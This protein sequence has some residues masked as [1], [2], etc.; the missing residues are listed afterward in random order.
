[1]GQRFTA[2]EARQR[3]TPPVFQVGEGLGTSHHLLV[4]GAAQ[5]DTPQPMASRAPTRSTMPNFFGLV[6]G[7]GAQQE[8]E[9]GHMGEYFAKYQAYGQE[10]RDALSFQDFVQ[11]QRD[12]RPRDH[13][14]GHR[15]YH[16]GGTQRTV[17]R[18]HLPTFDG[19]SQCS[20]KAWVERL[21]TS[22]QLDRITEGEAIK[23]ATFHL[24]DEDTQ[25][26]GE[27]VDTP[28]MTLSLIH[29]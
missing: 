17:S 21:D 11:L 8:A 23:M 13:H 4:H 22:F 28:G 19:S 3:D 7:V 25:D 27:H 12:S 16:E 9:P 20:E 14:R 15:H 6:T 10:F 18:F 1:M 5:R 2:V 24:E 26:H 29:I